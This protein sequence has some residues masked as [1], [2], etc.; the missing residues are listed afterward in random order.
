MNAETP[1]IYAGLPPDLVCPDCGRGSETLWRLVAIGDRLAAE[2][3]HH[4]LSPHNDD[5]CEAG[6]AMYD[7]HR[8]TEA[9]RNETEPT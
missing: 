9:I 4:G 8:L 3:E 5:E 1:D 2:L 7:W 6:A